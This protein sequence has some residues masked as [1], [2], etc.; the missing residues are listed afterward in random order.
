MDPPMIRADCFASHYLDCL[1]N[2]VDRCLGMSYKDSSFKQL[3][4]TTT[5]RHISDS[6]F[7]VDTISM[8]ALSWLEAGTN[9][10]GQ[11]CRAAMKIEKLLLSLITI[12]NTILE[13]IENISIYNKFIITQAYYKILFWI[14]SI[15][16]NYPTLIHKSSDNR[17]DRRR[18]KESAYP[19]R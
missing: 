3:F 4:I 5:T 6:M 7:N 17:S 1:K 12:S 14:E 16:G 15:E 8:H 19:L 9:W 13:Q 2:M 18:N 10:T 11:L